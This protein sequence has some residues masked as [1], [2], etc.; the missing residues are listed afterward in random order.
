MKLQRID[1]S[2][3]EML[4][5]IIR[6]KKCCIKMIKFTSSFESYV[7]IKVIYKLGGETI[8]EQIL[9]QHHAE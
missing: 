1:E 9:E 5:A 3:F 8:D 2:N 4:S 6:S 7:K